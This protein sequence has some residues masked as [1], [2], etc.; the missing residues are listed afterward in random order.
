MVD[1]IAIYKEEKMD[2][3]PV[4]FIQ[5]THTHKSIIEMPAY[6][7]TKELMHLFT[8]Q[9]AAYRIRTIMSEIDKTEIKQV[10]LRRFKRLSINEMY[11]AFKLHRS[12][13]L[14]PEVKPYD[15][16]SVTFV[17]QILEAYVEW[18]RKIRQVNNLELPQNAIRQEV[19]DEEKRQYIISGVLRSYD[20]YKEHKMLGSGSA[21]I[22]DVLYDIGLLPTDVKTKKEFYDLAKKSLQMQITLERTSMGVSLA[23][24]RGLKNLQDSLE[25]KN[26][27][28][29]KIEAMKLV[30]CDYFKRTKKEELETILK[31]K[32]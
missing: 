9:I 26:S 25:K 6:D 7:L 22:Y 16:I 18:K 11:Y 12:G 20:E 27:T 15:Y 21:Y 8:Y 24:L 19:S 23:D 30:V 3:T 2:L 5:D 1:K 29:V 17:S 32:L 4:A 14:M 13:E 28:P 31:E 10:I